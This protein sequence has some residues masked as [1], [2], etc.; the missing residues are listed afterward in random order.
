MAN[1]LGLALK[2]SADTTQLKLTPVER[3]LQTL[4][5]EADKVTSVFDEFAKSSEAAANA[6]AST[7]KAL[8]DLTAA[9]QAGTITAE[10]FARSFEDIRNAA[11]EEA[12]ALR[13]AAQIT[14]SVRTPFERFQ[15]SAAE[16]SQ[17]LQAGR[18]TQETYNRAIENSARGLTDAER[19]AAG[20]AARTA[21]IS[22]AGGQARLQFNELSGIFSILPGPLGNIAGRI[23]G[24]TS[25]S[26]GLS[27][28]FAGGLSQGIT[29]IAG[30]I[31]SLVNPFTIAAGAIIGVG[32]AAQQVLAGLLQLEDRVEK[33][34]NTADK[35]GVS[36]EFIQTLEEAANRSGTSIDAVS[37]AFG[38]LQKSV[39]GVDEE[40]KAAQKALAEIGVTSQELADLDPQE[41]YQRIGQAL[42]GIEDPAKRTATA[43]ALFGKAGADLIPFFNNIAGAAADMERFNATLSQTDRERIDGLGSAFDGVQVALRGFGQELLTP[44]IGITQSISEGLSPVITTLGQNLGALFDALSPVTSAL[45]LVVNIVSQV[46]A[47]LGR[48]IGTVL[49]PFAAVGRLISGAF[50]AVSQAFTAVFS[51]IN[52]VVDSFRSFFRFE[53]AASALSSILSRIGEVVSETL[54]PV[55]EKLSEIGQRVG[56]ILSAVFAKF[57]AFFAAF[58]SG[59]VKRIGEI[60]SRFLEVT[61]IADTVAAAAELIGQVFGSAYEIVSNVL[62]TIGGLI[63]QVL[64]FAEDWLGITATIAEPVEATIE[65]NTGDTIAEL[66]AENKELGKVIDGITKAVE[67]AKATSVGFG[68]AGFD[69]AVRFEQ[70]IAAL[71]DKLAAGLFNEETFRIE[72]EKA[73]VAFDA[74]LQ[75]IEQDAKLEIQIEENAARTLQGLRQQI[76]DVVADSARLGQAGFDAA[77]QYQTALEELQRQFEQGVINETTLA[78]EANKARAI[79]DDQVKS[80]EERNKAQQQQIE[81]DRKVIESLFQVS[82]ASQ[83]ITDGIVAIDRE[84]ARVQEEFARAVIEM[85]GAAAINAQRRIDELTQKQGELE[86]QLQAAA[87]GFEGGFEKAFE[88]TGA[89]FSRLAQ[90]AQQFGDAGFDAA[91]RLQDGIALAQEQAKD[92]ILNRQAYEAEVARQQ[93]LFEQEIANVKAIADERKR[94]ND[95]V[96]QAVNLARFGGD[97]QRLAAAQRV[98]EFEREIIRVQQEVQTA[99]AAGDQGAVN[100]GI[101]RLGLLD[102]VAAKERDVASGRQQIEQQIAQQRQQYL[103]ALGEQQKKAE[104]EQKKFAEERAKIAEA[105]NQR[106]RARIKELNTLGAG[107]IKSNDIRT[108]EGAALFLQLAANQQ[109]PALIEARLQ[110]R[111]LTE[112]RQAIVGLAESFGLA[113]VSIPGVTG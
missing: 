112:I 46:G 104:E 18:I 83:K 22:S 87:Q 69:A 25:A 73:R 21:D 26:E 89:N 33:L 41:Q 93:Q 20:L 44:F 40:S 63:E 17:Q 81:N 57:Q 7:A 53:G 76:N 47:T 36:F 16:L 2:I 77:L 111:R 4:A 42:A 35:L 91:V 12:G 66:I 5:K 61:G 31:T 50:D 37:A 54:S 71:K 3:A 88:A 92:G 103:Q 48:V 79:Y 8:Q 55:F 84:V 109:D 94:V 49:E 60:V 67:E 9:R 59:I 108:A 23:S 30:S 102:Q 110:T 98:A 72:A 78:A 38:R 80:V 32:A 100:A 24:V 75:R 65:V 39:L 62:S 1:I 86:T 14:E 51:A 74:E 15:E 13:R 85:D 106:Q 52:R 45:G 27:R 19:A 10:E 107:V 82:D 56:A 99:R 11:T 105:E 70:S 58:A 43:I 101:Q 95:A 113:T 6:Q 28:V 64:A 34:G 68:Q 96:D 90:Q 29:S 97:Q